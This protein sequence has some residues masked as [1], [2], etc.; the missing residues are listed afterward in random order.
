MSYLT[1][2]VG[3]GTAALFDNLGSHFPITK[4]IWNK[5]SMPM[6]VDSSLAL[7]TLGSIKGRMCA[8]FTTA[9]LVAA[10]VLHL[11][12][13]V[14]RIVSPFFNWSKGMQWRIADGVIAGV[15]SP[16][17]TT[18]IAGQAALAILH[19]GLLF[20]PMSPEEAQQ[21]EEET[22]LKADKQKSLKVL[23]L[24][25][26]ASFEAIKAQYKILSLQ[27]HPDKNHDENATTRF[28]EI[29]VAYTTLRKLHEKE[30]LSKR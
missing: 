19:P 6:K 30:L 7:H 27:F 15:S 20:A 22:Q 12:V 26:N 24:E 28:Q 25:S 9:L 23:G 14:Y 1:N 13:D 10:T 21:K 2:A 16:I 8:V 4:G 29:S 18:L 17:K 5:G 11:P 3:S